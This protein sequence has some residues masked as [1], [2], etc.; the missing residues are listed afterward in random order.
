[1][2]NTRQIDRRPT[3]NEPNRPT[4]NH[5]RRLKTKPIFRQTGMLRPLAAPT[6]SA[7]NDLLVFCCYP[8]MNRDERRA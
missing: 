4:L 3:G 1:M 2:K 7:R 6:P 8:G 5:R